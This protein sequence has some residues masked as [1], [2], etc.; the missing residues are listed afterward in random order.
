VTAL[1]ALLTTQTTE[2]SLNYVQKRSR[3]ALSLSEGTEST[4][5]TVVVDVGP[6]GSVGC[7]ARAP[8][9][10]SASVLN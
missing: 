3:Q 7:V 2:R 1:S 9:N 8:S 5:N 6:A 4:Y 10:I